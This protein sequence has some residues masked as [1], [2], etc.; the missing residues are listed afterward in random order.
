MRVAMARCAGVVMATG[1]AALPAH[2]H[3]QFPL[4]LQTFLN[5]QGA[6]PLGWV[7]FGLL[8]PREDGVGFDW[9][10]E[11][12]AGGN[13][14]TA[15][16]F[17][18]TSQ[19]TLLGG[20]RDRLLRFTED[21]CGAVP[22]AVP[23][24][25]GL[26]RSLG[27]HAVAPLVA[28]GAGTGRVFWSTDDGASFAATPL[29]EDGAIP[30]RILVEGTAEA[31]EL[32]V[33]WRFLMDGHTE[34]LRSAPDGTGLVRV[35]LMD[36]RAPYFQL[37]TRDGAREHSLYM[38]DDGVAHDRLLR[39]DD[40]TG[41]VTAVLLEGDDDLTLGASADGQKVAM[42]GLTTALRVS[43]D[44][45]ATFATRASVQ[46]VRNAAWGGGDALY[47]A[48][49]NWRDGFAFGRSNDLGVTFTGMGRFVDILGVHQC[50]SRGPGCE[51]GADA[52]CVPGQGNDVLASCGSYYPALRELFGIGADA[53]EPAGAD[54]GA[55][56]EDAG[57][58]Q[59]PSCGSCSGG[60]EGPPWLGLAWLVALAAGIRRLRPRV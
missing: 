21:R 16:V 20:A 37:I 12:M 6:D 31:P 38:R 40:R 58:G 48:A 13:L 22:A 7:T 45:A 53:G 25:R 15:P 17:V 19:G 24:D 50:A 44:A 8:E 46:Q 5:A 56:G 47:V 10:C 29:A 54:A 27:V 11:E 52:G 3:G 1:L 18:R 51:I 34:M 60:G 43:V 36:P 30:A 9:I 14:N 23:E 59:G 35:R 41:E 33:L 42:G 2:A 32:L 49:D 26:L 4:P 28:A 57:A 39:V 55:S